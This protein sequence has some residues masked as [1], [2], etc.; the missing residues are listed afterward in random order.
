MRFRQR[1]ERFRGESVSNHGRVGRARD[2]RIHADALPGMVDG[3]GSR[4]QRHAAFGG[5][6]SHGVCTG[7]VGTDR[8]GH[9]DD[10]PAALMDHVRQYGA[11]AEVG[12]GQVDGEHPVPGLFVG[13][14]NRPIV[15]N[16]RAVEQ[17][18]DAPES[19]KRYLNH[20]G[21]L[22]GA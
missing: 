11:A 5:H 1:R 9:I 8:R 3:H 10:G 12:A 19:L 13:F 22:R 21:D 14:E 4:E 2:E 15:K 16:A 18:I 6:I 17:D 7:I 20:A